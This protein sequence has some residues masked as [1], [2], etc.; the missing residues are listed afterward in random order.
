MDYF[1]SEIKGNCASWW[2][3]NSF[4]TR[5]ISDNNLLLRSNIISVILMYVAKMSVTHNEGEQIKQSQYIKCLH[6]I[7]HTIWPLSYG[8]S[9][10]SHYWGWTS[11]PKTTH[12]GSWVLQQTGLAHWTRA[13]SYA[14]LCCQ[15]QISITICSHFGQSEYW[16]P[17]LC[18]TIKDL[19]WVA[20]AQRWEQE[21]IWPT[22]TLLC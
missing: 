19:V 15:L 18:S 2:V 21:L 10:N 16:T 6:V 1:T 11:F 12:S 3:S 7:L 14:H 9:L 22:P 13:F 8:T 5:P 4:P 17:P 20:E